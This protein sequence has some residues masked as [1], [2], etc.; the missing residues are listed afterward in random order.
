MPRSPTKGAELAE[1]FY[2]R[3]FERF[4]G[5]QAAICNNTPMRRQQQHL[6]STLAM[7]IES[8]RD[9]DAVNQALVEL[10]ERHVDYGAAPSHY[11]AVKMVLLNTLESFAGSLWSEALEEAWHDGL[12]GII[13]VMLAAHRQAQSR[14]AEVES[15]QAAVA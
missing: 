5:S 9:P 7:V 6:L 2:Q 1:D 10:A 13:N 15:D 8:L 12:E 4:P 11:H 3:L 14:K